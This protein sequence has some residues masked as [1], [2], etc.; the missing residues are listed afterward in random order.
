MHTTKTGAV[1]T[2]DEF[3]TF[4]VDDLLMG[5]DIQKVQ[6]I[7]RYI[8]VTQAP[9]APNFVRGVVN[10]RGEVVTIIDLRMILGLEPT[11][12]T[13]RTRTVIV[14]SQ[15]EN[16]GLLVDR[17]ADVIHTRG[18]ET[19]PPPPNVS[20]VDGKFFHGVCKLE[21]ELLIILDIEAIVANSELE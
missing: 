11:T 10:L 9:H 8:E 5:I 1:L 13:D 18:S 14:H 21:H 17:I 4:Y 7:N 6:E 3:A 20:G 19:E 12:L 16:I 15:G 2:A